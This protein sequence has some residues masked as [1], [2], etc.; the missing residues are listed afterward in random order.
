M[1]AGILG[2]LLVLGI[3]ISILGLF[4]KSNR[5][6]KEYVDATKSL[7]GHG[8]FYY[9]GIPFIL[10][11]VIVMGILFSAKHDKPK[12]ELSVA[13][14]FGSNNRLVIGDDNNRLV[15]GD[16]QR[17]IRDK[18]ASGM[19]PEQVTQSMSNR[20]AGKDYSGVYTNSVAGFSIQFPSGWVVQESSAETGAVVAKNVDDGSSLKVSR[21]YNNDNSPLTLNK[22]MMVGERFLSQIQQY[23]PSARLLNAN[24]ISNFNGREAVSTLYELPDTKVIGFVIV[25]YKKYAYVIGF[26]GSMD[27]YRGRAG[28]SIGS[29]KIL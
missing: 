23:E 25:P 11:S 15:T 28:S 16:E 24:V 22:A 8:V 7:I 21:E 27:M 4:F 19:S 10:V 14:S 17:E 2:L 1:V 29:F 3:V 13:E 6:D 18:I 9:I 12:E 5:E 20:K 26:E